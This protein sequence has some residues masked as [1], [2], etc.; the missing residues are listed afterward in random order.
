MPYDEQLAARVRDAIAPEGPVV[1][2][3]MFGGL[4]FVLDGNLAVCASSGGGLLVRVPDSAAVTGEG[5]EP[6]V[7]GGRASRTWV[8]VSASALASDDDLAAWVGRGVA[9]ARSLPP[10]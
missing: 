5:V 6:M 2:K 4:G 9:V 7:M 8:E 1:E 10:K 3:R